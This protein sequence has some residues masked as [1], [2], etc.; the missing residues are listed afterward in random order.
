MNSSDDDLKKVSISTPSHAF[1]E[2]K[3]DLLGGTYDIGYAKP[4]LA[5][6][7]QKGRSGNPNGRPKTKPRQV[8]PI[9]LSPFAE[10]VLK[11]GRRKVGGVYGRAQIT[12]VEA[13][14]KAQVKA[15]MKGNPAAQKNFLERCWIAEHE[16]QVDIAAEHAKFEAY[17]EHCHAAISEAKAKGEDV[18]EFLPHPDDILIEPGKRVRIT[19]PVCAQSQAKLEETVLLR[20]CLLDQHE[21]EE[22]MPHSIRADGM[23]TATLLFVVMINNGLPARY[24]MSDLDLN[25]RLSIQRPYHQRQLLKSMRQLWRNLG[26]Q[27]PRG[28]MMPWQ[29]DVIQVLNEAIDHY[30]AN[31]GGEPLCSCTWLR[32]RSG[33]RRERAGAVS[34]GSTSSQG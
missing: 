11:E 20:D 24:R 34:V 16:E 19:G 32:A 6:R 30:H 13:V 3:R 17:V 33:L 5:N 9:V 25:I 29:D 23:P 14:M 7:F 15:A 22:R 1:I 10:A 21:M 28:T 31:M 12:V 8:G 4:P 2:A 27:V 26:I 18:P